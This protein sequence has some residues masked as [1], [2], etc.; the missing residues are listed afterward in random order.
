MQKTGMKPELDATLRWLVT[1]PAHVFDFTEVFQGVKSMGIKTTRMQIGFAIVALRNPRNGGHLATVGPNGLRLR[2]RYAY[3][4]A[5]AAVRKQHPPVKHPV[6]PLAE[7]PSVLAIRQAHEEKRAQEAKEAA[8]LA[9][10]HEA[11]KAARQSERD[12]KHEA[13]EKHWE[14]L[15]EARRPVTK[16]PLSPERAKAAEMKAIEDGE[17][18]EDAK[19]IAALIT[20]AAGPLVEVKPLPKPKK[21]KTDA[22]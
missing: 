8:V 10:K 18:P 19:M 14:T 20:E 1:Q 21:V 16:I 9:K 2:E 13:R 5:D 4:P 11:R 22:Q 7:H 15:P 17:T 6:I 12:K 3:L